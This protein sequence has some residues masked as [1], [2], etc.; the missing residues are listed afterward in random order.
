[1][2][3][4]DLLESEIEKEVISYWRSVGLF[5][6]KVPKIKTKGKRKLNGEDNGCPDV[7]IFHKGRSIAIENKTQSG[8]QS[9]DQIKFESRLRTQGI[10][11]FICRSLED[12]R[13][14]HRAILEL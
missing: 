7:F 6:W 2:T 3:L 12:A 9:E 14:I 8:R 11:Y 4:M 13:N 5:A 10:L 1:M